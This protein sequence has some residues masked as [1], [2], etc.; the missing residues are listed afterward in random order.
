MNVETQGRPADDGWKALTRD[1]L[2][3]EEE[4][5]ILSPLLGTLWPTLETDGPEL[6]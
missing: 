5:A 3:A 2:Q 6:C 4:E 1:N